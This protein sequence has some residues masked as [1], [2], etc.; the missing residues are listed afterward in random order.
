MRSRARAAAPVNAGRVV[1]NTT[2]GDCRGSRVGVSLG[3]ASEFPSWTDE[4]CA[5]RPIVQWSTPGSTPGCARYDSRIQ[6]F[7]R[8]PVLT[9]AIG[10]RVQQLG[11]RSCA[12]VAQLDSPGCCIGCGGRVLPGIE[13]AFLQASAD[14]APSTPPERAPCAPPKPH[15]TMTTTTR[16]RQPYDRTS[17]PRRTIST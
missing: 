1:E 16:A 5:I 2:A 12:W 15:T 14:L 6:N 8:R 9:K 7:S 11:W 10:Y 13:F 3:V 17:P 4:C